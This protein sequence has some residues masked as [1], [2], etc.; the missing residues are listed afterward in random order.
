VAAQGIA[1]AGEVKSIAWAILLATVYSWAEYRNIS[2]HQVAAENVA[3]YAYTMLALIGG[4]LMSLV[5]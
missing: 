4:F 5:P 3:F 2:G 1:G